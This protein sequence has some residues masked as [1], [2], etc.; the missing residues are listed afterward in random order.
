MNH[1]PPVRRN[2]LAAALA[3][4]LLAACLPAAAE[5][6]PNP[7]YIGVSQAF[8]HDSNPYRLPDSVPV[9]SDNISS[10]GVVAGIDQPFGRQHFYAN[11]VARENRYNTLKELNNTSYNLGAGLDW[12]SIERLSGSLSY[13]TSKNLA[14]YG[15]GGLLL[16]QEKNVEHDQNFKA[17][18][19]LGLAALFALEGGYQRNTVDYSNV[20]YDPFDYNENVYN[21]GV[22]YRPGGSLTLHLGGR[23]TRGEYPHRGDGAGGF[24]PLHLKRNDADLMADWTLTGQS[25]ISARLSYERQSYDDAGGSSFH[26]FTGSFG[27]DYRPTGKLHFSTYLARDTGTTLQYQ[28]FGPFLFSNTFGRVHKTAQVKADWDATAKIRLTAIGRYV[29]RDLDNINAFVPVGSDN[30]RYLSLGAQY[31]ALRSLLF[32]CQVSREIRRSS[33]PPEFLQALTYNFHD[34]LASCSA[35]FTFQ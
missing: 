14:S 16:L 29:H 33:V 6:E 19:Q 28:Q 26:G 30:T 27:W 10:T 18:A 17:R 34:N 7:Y 23:T 11:G 13:N 22:I 21:L 24:R 9:T 12:S 25:A 15:S 2:V 32:S 1:R 31:Q 5:D 20:Q 35:Q 3:S 8:T 4:G